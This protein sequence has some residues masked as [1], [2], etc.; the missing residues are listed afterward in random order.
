MMRRL[1]DSDKPLE[2]C[3]PEESSLEGA[4]IGKCIQFDSLIKRF[5][6]MR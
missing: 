2:I 1:E 5:V 4:A 3:V 6:D